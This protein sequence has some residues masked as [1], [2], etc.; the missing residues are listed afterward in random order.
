MDQFIDISG[1]A[2]WI[3]I[4]FWVI[5]RIIFG[6]HWLRKAGLSFF[7][8]PGLMGTSKKL[9][10]E[11]K[12]REVKEE[13]L[14]E[15]GVH[16]FWRFTRAGVIGIFFIALPTWL[17]IWVLSNQNKLIQYQNERINTQTIL[18]SV[19][20]IMAQQQTGLLKSQDEKFGIQNQLLS[21]QTDFIERQDQK[22]GF[23][24]NLFANQNQLLNYQNIKVDSQISLMS[25]QNV[26]L[27]TQN[28]RLNLQNNLIEAERRGA[29]VILM[30]NIMD[31]MNEEIKQ[32]KLDTTFNDS[33]GYSLSDP[34]IGRIAALSQ[35]FLPYRYLDGDTLTE[36]VVSPE[37]GQLLLSLV[38]SRLDS[39]TYQK[40]YRSTT[41]SHAYLERADLSEADLSDADLSEV[42]FLTIDQLKTVKTL[43]QCKNLDP[44]LKQQLQKGKPC[45]FTEEG[46]ND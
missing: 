8:G 6:Q 16:V 40:I 29:L 11:L 33:L 15:F 1:I 31:Q 12:N 37:R 5:L 38:K 43:Y 10:Q 27:D 9:V 3:I 36:K 39:S 25:F 20:T 42:R 19:Q 4:G 45:L 41:F 23:Q 24:N 26:L 22:L 28:Y 32:Q 44:Q 13:T 7:A 34:L 21:K 2:L 18:D 35:G 46:C 30:S 14:T 17:S